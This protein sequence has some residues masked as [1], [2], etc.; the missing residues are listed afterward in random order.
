MKLVLASVGRLKAGP[1]RELF[2]RYLKRA[3]ALGPSV[4]ISGF[5]CREFEESRGRTVEERRAAEG[6]AL[7][8]AA[9]KGAYLCALDERGASITSAGWAAEIGR[10]RDAGAAAYVV[11]IGGPDG[12]DP[13][14][15]AAARATIA[16]GALTWPHQLVRVMAAEQIYRCFTI[17]AGHPYHR[18]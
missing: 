2:E 14:I 16:F 11:M 3:A 1:E 10:A 13:E 5:A 15:R 12:L 4:G 9:G 8:E 17:L 6:R 18:A 7:L